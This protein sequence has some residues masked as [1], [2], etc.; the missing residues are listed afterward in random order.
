VT[1]VRNFGLIEATGPQNNRKLVLRT[2]DPD[3]KE[4]WRHEISQSELTFPK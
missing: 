1:G 3:G 4:L 2:L